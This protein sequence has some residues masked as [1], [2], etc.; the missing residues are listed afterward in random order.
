MIKQILENS[1]RSIESEKAQRI[2]QVS[3]KVM[4]EKIAPHNREIDQAREKAIAELSTALNQKIV[5]L[6]EDFS[7][8]KQL[9]VEKGE[10]NKAE[11]A[12]T[13]IATETSLIEL[14]YNN[15]IKALQSQIEKLGE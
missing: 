2:A 9:L 1:I 14:E 5:A 3:Q 15:A 11:F 13:A 7:A 10:K 8:Q 4:A 6:Q 12:K